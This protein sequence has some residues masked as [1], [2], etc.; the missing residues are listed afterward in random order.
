MTKLQKHLKQL[1]DAHDACSNHA[2]IIKSSKLCGCFYCIK[3]FNPAKKKIKEWIDGG[4]TAL[5][6][7]CGIDTVIGSES[8]F[9]IT[10]KFLN[11]MHEHWFNHGIKI[12][13]KNGRVQSVKEE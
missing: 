1:E 12:T 5:C 11:S 13:M 6:P 9:P 7:Y 3:I 2:D 4:E 8:K 10:F